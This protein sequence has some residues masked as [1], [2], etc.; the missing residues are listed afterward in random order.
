L[1]LSESA[2][3]RNYKVTARALHPAQALYIGREKLMYFL[4][5]HCNICMQ[6]VQFLSED[7]HVLYHKFGTLRK[8]AARGRRKFAGGKSGAIRRVT[9]KLTPHRASPNVL[10][11]SF[12]SDQ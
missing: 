4:R 12:D 2:A 10:A 7:L 6:I 3:G 11:S 8:S 1:G 9:H 5:D